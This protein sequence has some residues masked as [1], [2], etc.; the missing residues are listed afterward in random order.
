MTIRHRYNREKRRKSVVVIV[1][2]VGGGT[3]KSDGFMVRCHQDE[4]SG[5]AWKTNVVEQEKD[6][7]TE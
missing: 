7:E 1:D 6:S 3:D 2:D 4:N 5:A